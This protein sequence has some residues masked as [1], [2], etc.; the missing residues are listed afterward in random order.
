[1]NPEVIGNVWS[2]NKSEDGKKSKGNGMDIKVEHD[3]FVLD[4]PA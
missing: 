4:P 2:D 1:M 3:G